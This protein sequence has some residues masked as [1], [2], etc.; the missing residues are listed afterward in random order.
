MKPAQVMAT[1]ATHNPIRDEQRQVTACRC[2]PDRALTSAEHTWHLAEA[3][4]RAVPDSAPPVPDRV[5]IPA[6]ELTEAYRGHGAYFPVLGAGHG[7][8]A[9]VTGLLLNIE[10]VHQDGRLLWVTVFHPER[11]REHVYVVKRTSWV[12]LA[13]PTH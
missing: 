11:R 6:G 2:D 7:P 1:F 13:S 3:I 10:P 9:Y 5:L 8:D 4:A 12:E